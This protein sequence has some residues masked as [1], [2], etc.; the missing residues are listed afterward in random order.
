M[1]KVVIDQE[2][3][4][5]K[6]IKKVDKV[7]FSAKEYMKNHDSLLFITERCVI[8]YTKDGFILEEVAPGI[9]IQTQIID[10]CDV[11]LIMPEGGPKLM[12]ALIFTEKGI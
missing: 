11:D 1:K 3:R 10:Q 4:F 8:R 6:F 12:D 5:R 9:D 2:G 7:T